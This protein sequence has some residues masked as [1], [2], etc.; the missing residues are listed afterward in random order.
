MVENAKVEVELEP[1]MPLGE[2]TSDLKEKEMEEKIRTQ[3]IFAKKKAEMKKR[4]M[5]GGSTGSGEEGEGEDGETE[6]APIPP[7]VPEIL[8][9]TCGTVIGC[10][11]FDL[12]KKEAEVFANSL[13]VLIGAQNSK[14]YHLLII[15]M[16]TASRIIRCRDKIKEKFEALSM[17]KQKEKKKEEEAKAKEAADR[18]KIEEAKKGFIY[19]GKQGRQTYSDNIFKSLGFGVKPQ[20]APAPTNAV[21]P[22]GASGQW[23]GK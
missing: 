19:K 22:E 1:D 3:L 20:E 14:F 18:A 12:D 17:Q 11:K 23:F 2:A 21:V 4:I 5:G 6:G 7:E 10:P 13:T 9:H 15:L 16:I 8:F